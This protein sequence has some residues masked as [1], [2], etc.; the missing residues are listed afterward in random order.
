MTCPPKRIYPITHMYLSSINL[1]T[2]YSIISLVK[3]VPLIFALLCVAYIY[4][5]IRVI[6]VNPVEPIIG[7]LISCTLIY[8]WYL[9][10]VPNGLLTLFFPCALLL[11]FHSIKRNTKNWL[12][13]LLTVIFLFDCISSCSQLIFLGLVLLTV[14]WALFCTYLPKNL[15]LKGR[16]SKNHEL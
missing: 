3:I 16:Y 13:L 11:I 8:G 7:A 15:S 6:A 14:P 5:S 10:F 1:I 9:D 4:L 12:I 2:D